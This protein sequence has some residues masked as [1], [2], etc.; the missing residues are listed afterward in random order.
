MEKTYGEGVIKKVQQALISIKDSA[1]LSAFPRSN[2][3]AADNAMY[4][5]I[6]DTAIEVGIIRQ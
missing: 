1:I 5:P 4:K 3:I 2:F 6:L